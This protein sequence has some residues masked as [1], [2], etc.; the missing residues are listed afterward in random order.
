[1]MDTGGWELKT[2][3]SGERAGG[4]PNSYFLIPNSNRAAA[5]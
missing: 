3:N 1:M 2:Q 4:I 5:Q